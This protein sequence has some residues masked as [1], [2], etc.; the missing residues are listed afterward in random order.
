MYSTGNFLYIALLLPCCCWLSA[1]LL[2]C[3]YSIFLLL[4]HLYFTSTPYYNTPLQQNLYT[5]ILWSFGTYR[6][7]PSPTEP[8]HAPIRMMM[9]F[10]YLL[11]R[12]YSTLY[13]LHVQR[14]KTAHNTDK[15]IF[16][17][18]KQM[19]NCVGFFWRHKLCK[20]WKTQNKIFFLYKTDVTFAQFGEEST[21]SFWF[22]ALTK[23]RKLFLFFPSDVISV[24]FSVC[25]L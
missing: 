20:I 2:A 23:E 11:G 19:F 3:K 15:S 17:K 5:V 10:F 13:S 1:C 18:P 22:R 6:R 12:T 14:N 21:I 8:N 7:L 16:Q 9:N 25:L 4:F 24:L